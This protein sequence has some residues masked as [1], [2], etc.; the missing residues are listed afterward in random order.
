[1]ADD[2]RLVCDSHALADGG[3]GVRFQM[4]WGAS[5]LPCFAIRY[6][7][8]VH[9]YLNT[10]PHQGTELDWVEGAFFDDSKSYLICA[11]HGA[12]FQPD[13]GA[14]WAGPCK[15]QKLIK[16]KVQEIDGKVFW[17]DD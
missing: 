4:A 6:R 2:Q 5:G 10:C 13:T 17:Q 15:G 9:A 7:G 14:C 16:V 1:M 11:T 12:V 3:N 8:A